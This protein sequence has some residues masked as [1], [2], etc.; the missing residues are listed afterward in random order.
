MGLAQ[1]KAGRTLEH[2][3]GKHGV[4]GREV[5][6]AFGKLLYS[7]YHHMPRPN[8]VPFGDPLRDLLAPMA[9]SPLAIARARRIQRVA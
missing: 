2:E 1:R 5:P 3:M 4:G 6:L 7:T 9:C 8:A